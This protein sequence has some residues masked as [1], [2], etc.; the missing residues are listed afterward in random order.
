MAI[1]QLAAVQTFPNSIHLVLPGQSAS[2]AL[3]AEPLLGPCRLQDVF[4]G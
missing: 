1:S 3:F 4:S 2:V